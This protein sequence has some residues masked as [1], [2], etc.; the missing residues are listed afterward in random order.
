[1]VDSISETIQVKHPGYDLLWS[2]L[3]SKRIQAMRSSRSRRCGIPDVDH[4][5]LAEVLPRWSLDHTFSRVYT[6][7]TICFSTLDAGWSLSI[8]G[9]CP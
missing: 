7:S 1:M 8:L 3:H 9:V 5:V 6:F 2:P 4:L